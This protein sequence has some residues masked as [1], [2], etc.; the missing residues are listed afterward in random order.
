MTAARTP[1]RDRGETSIE[2]VLLVPVLL[3]VLF[4]GVHVASLGRAGQVAHLAARRA[5]ETAAF[6]GTS[7]MGPVIARST[8]LQVVHDLG[9]TVEGPVLVTFASGDP[10][11]TVRLRVSGIVPGLP[12]VIGRSA[13]VAS[14]RFIDADV[15]R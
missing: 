11:V 10:T 13:T 14:E 1:G 7:G 2:T 3:S 4:V 5:A 6:A 8:A 15:R 9:G 12:I